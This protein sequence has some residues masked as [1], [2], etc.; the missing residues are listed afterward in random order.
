M[1]VITGIMLPLYKIDRSD[2]TDANNIK[3]LS[4]SIK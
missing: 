2:Q 3:V 1:H 4:N